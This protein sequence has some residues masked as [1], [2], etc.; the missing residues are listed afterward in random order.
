M[1]LSKRQVDKARAAADEVDVERAKIRECRNL[2][3]E[4]EAKINLAMAQI[5]AFLSLA[6]TSTPAD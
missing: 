4:S 2:M 1:K 5:Q 6:D 3:A